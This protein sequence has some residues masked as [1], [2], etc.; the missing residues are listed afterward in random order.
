MIV[1]EVIYGNQDPWPSGALGSGY[2]LHRLAAGVSGNEPGNWFL[3]SA[4]PGARD[5][6]D[7]DGDG[8]PDDWE[9]LYDFDPDEPLDAVMD[10]DEDGMNNLEEYLAGTDPLV[11]GSVLRFEWVEAGASGVSFGFRAVTGRGYTV[12]YSDDP[13]SGSW[14]KLED[15]NAGSGATVLAVD[16]EMVPTNGSRYY[17]VVTPTRP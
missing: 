10:A 16:D 5:Y 12:L 11:A 9:L 2:A 8:M 7:R 15:V 13:A 3:A 6:R 17:R 1:D 4:A 14:L